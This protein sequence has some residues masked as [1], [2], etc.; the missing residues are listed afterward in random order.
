MSN[1]KGEG[2]VLTRQDALMGLL[3]LKIIVIYNS[4][5]VNSSVLVD[6]T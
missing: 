2:Q 5:L 6:S 3:L 4:I 1:L